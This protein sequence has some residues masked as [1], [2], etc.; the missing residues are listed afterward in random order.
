MPIHV[1][2]GHNL[3]EAGGQEAVTITNQTMPAHTHFVQGQSA[4]GTQVVPTGAFLASASNLYRSPD[5]L[6]A[7][8]SETITNVGGSQAHTNMAP[9]LTIS[10]CIALQGIFPSPN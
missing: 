10:F 2:S 6:V 5:N 1:G 8:A 9:Y 4:A 3:G 7:L